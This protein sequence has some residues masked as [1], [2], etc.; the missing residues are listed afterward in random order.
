MWTVDLNLSKPFP[1]VVL[2][3]IHFLGLLGFLYKQRVLKE[4]GSLV[5]LEKPLTSQVLVNG[6]V[7]RVEFKSLSTVYFSCGWYGHLKGLRPSVVADQNSARNKVTDFGQTTE[8]L[9]SVETEKPF[10]AWMV[11]EHKSR[12]NQ[13]DNCNQRAKKGKEPDLIFWH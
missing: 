11:V 12:R 7:Q 2:N 5:D 8:N 3:W 9:V 1:S 13:N 10:S 6:K 4:I